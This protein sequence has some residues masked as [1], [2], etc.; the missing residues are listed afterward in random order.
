M[1]ATLVTGGLTGLGSDVARAMLARGERPRILT[2]RPGATPPEGASL[3]VGD[4]RDGAG[5]VTAL[6]GA[7]TVIHCASDAREADFATEIE[8]ARN[9]TRLASAAGVAHLLYISIIGVDRSDYPYYAAKRQAERSIEAGATPWTILRA[10]Q[11]HH[12]V[13]GLLRSWDDGAGALRVP[14]DMRFQ[15]VARHEVAKRLVELADAGPAGYALPMRG[16]ET[17]TIAAMA[18]AYLAALGRAGSVEIIPA[19]VAAPSVFRTGV[20][21]VVD[22][23]P[24]TRG[25]ETWA[26]FLRGQ[27]AGG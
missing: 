19:E 10:A 16:P 9:L 5:L 26:E 20:N 21:L 12:L 4:L 22:E 1:A 27:G 8:G 13:Y 14:P 23:A 24:A 17:L 11:F 15:S 6:A 18:A 3:A 7:A 25:H 2:H